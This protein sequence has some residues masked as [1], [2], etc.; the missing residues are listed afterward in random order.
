MAVTRRAPHALGHPGRIAAV[1]ASH[2]EDALPRA[3]GSPA[4]MACSSSANSS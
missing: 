2:V 1:A 3:K 4:R